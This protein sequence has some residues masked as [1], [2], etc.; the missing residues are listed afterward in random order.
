ME[1]ASEI[2]D[3]IFDICASPDE[4]GPDRSALL[5][6]LAVHAGLVGVALFV[7]WVVDVWARTSGS[8]L[9][10]GIGLVVG[11]GVG[12]VV[13]GLLHEWGHYAGAKLSGALAPR[14]RATA[15]FPVF[16]FDIER[17]STAQFVAMSSG[18]QLAQWAITIL[19]LVGGDDS[20]AAHGLQAGMLFSAVAASA[21]EAPILVD[22]LRR[23]SGIE[24][25]QAYL[26]NRGAIGKRSFGIGLAAVLI[27]AIVRAG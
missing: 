22:A 9:V 24:A 3:E 27:F 20:A 12:L 18:G 19:F 6:A 13:V 11:F 21:L 17:N 10:D 16:L 14:T 4:P 1:A 25:W 5:A 15:I 26:P 8:F 2:D 23:G 7:G